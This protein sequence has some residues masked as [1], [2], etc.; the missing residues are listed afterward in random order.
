MSLNLYTYC[1]NNPLIYYDPTGHNWITSGF[2]K[3]KGWVGEQV[4]NSKEAFR[5]LFIASEEER[6]EAFKT[7]YEYG[8]DNFYTN[9]VTGIGYGL[10]EVGDTFKDPVNQMHE[11]NKIMKSIVTND[12]GIK[13]GTFLYNSIK[14]VGTSVEAVGINGI[15][16]G[17]G[18][19]Q[20]GETMGKPI[21]NTMLL[22]I[23]YV[24]MQTG[25]ITEDDF[26]GWYD[27]WYAGAEADN[28]AFI[29]LVPNMINGIGNSAVGLYNNG[30]NF[31]NPHATLEQK[32]QA[33]GDFYN[34]AF[35][36]EAIKG[37]YDAGVPV[38]KNVAI[39]TR[40]NFINN[41]SPQFSM[42]GGTGISFTEGINAINN[43]GK[44]P[45]RNAVNTTVQNSIGSATKPIQDH[46]Y[47]TNKSKVYT[48][49]FKKIA[50][51]YKL[52]LNDAWNREYLPH[53]GRHPYA[54]HDYVLDQMKKFDSI[55]NGDQ[56]V[57]LKL[58]DQ[59]KQVINENPD[60][61]YKE[62]WNNP[63]GGTR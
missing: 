8:D 59:M 3:A 60:M 57:F 1:A 49:Q 63:Q 11:N 9:T 44:M 7:I 33:V 19:W 47:A 29:N 27:S 48:K 40:N 37:I 54:Y 55:A 25:N 12:L 56:G 16:L 31:F 38:L 10:A 22:G 15:N 2:N 51:K 39:N 18:A 20:M 26:Y 52:D 14:N 24:Q 61:L 4:D 5:I 62:Y 21:A 45:I 28:Q 6:D 23:N 30:L 50:D 17:K 13:E 35:T 46:H 32:T 41:T 53:Q 36:V 58:Y 42:A 34:V 43:M